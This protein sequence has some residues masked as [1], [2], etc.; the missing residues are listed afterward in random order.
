MD[1]PNEIEFTKEENYYSLLLKESMLCLGVTM[2][3]DA[4]CVC[5]VMGHVN[6]CVN[7]GRPQNLLRMSKYG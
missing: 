4:F 2:R 7:F 6:A 5:C 1:L 3:A